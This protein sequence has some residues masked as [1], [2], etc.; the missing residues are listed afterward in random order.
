MTKAEIRQT[1]SVLL[2]FISRAS[3]ENARPEEV[4]VLPGVVGALIQLSSIGP[5]D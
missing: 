3:Q 4:A 1:E 2:D 5:N